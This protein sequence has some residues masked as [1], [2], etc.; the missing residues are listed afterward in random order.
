VKH[1]FLLVLSLCL[2][3]VGYAN[4]NEYPPITPDNVMNLEE[5]AVLGNGATNDAVAWSPDGGIVVD[6]TRGLYINYSDGRVGVWA[7]PN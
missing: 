2:V 1:F 5:V 7:V 4:D 3:G 6:G